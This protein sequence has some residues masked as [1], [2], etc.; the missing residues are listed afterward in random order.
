M[1]LVAAA[2]R[3]KPWGSTAPLTPESESAGTLCFFPQ[4]PQISKSKHRQVH[5]NSGH[6]VPAIFSCDVGGVGVVAVAVYA[7]TCQFRVSDK[8]LCRNVGG[9][10]RVVLQSAKSNNVAFNDFRSWL[11]RRGC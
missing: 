2:R 10:Y 5:W 6:R 4:S 11:L 7:A 3:L 8:G 1:P 9:A